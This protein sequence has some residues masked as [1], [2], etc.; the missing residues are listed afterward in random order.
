MA[1]N[2]AETNEAAS[3][4]A[5][6]QPT[7]RTVAVDLDGVLAEYDG[8]QGVD[9]IGKPMPNAREFVHRLLDLGL[10][11]VIHTT[12]NNPSANR[13]EELGRGQMRPEE[14]K[15][16]LTGLVHQ[17]LSNHGFPVYHKRLTV[18]ADDGKPV[19]MSYVDDRAVVM[20]KPTP[21]VWYGRSC[22][23]A[24]DHCIRAIQHQAEQDGI[25]LRRGGRPRYFE[26]DDEQEAGANLARLQSEL[27]RSETRYQ[28]ELPRNEPDSGG[29]PQTA[30]ARRDLSEQQRREL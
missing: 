2:T 6:G 5:R 29:V 1:E 24:H 14:W 7:D 21:G 23:E 30:E 4:E 13:Q 12:R 16:Y 10:H 17:W 20:M 22:R 11:V 19:A 18:S 28:S 9:V 26:G 3:D 25:L 15:K 27:P 8:W